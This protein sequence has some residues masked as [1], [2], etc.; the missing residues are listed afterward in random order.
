LA[1]Q[2]QPARRRISIERSFQA[3]VEE[4]WKLWTTKEGIESW[5]GPE[6]FMVKVRTLD[7]RRGG[8]LLYDMTAIAREQMDFLKKAGMPLTTPSRV[9]YVDVILLKRL[10]FTQVA[11]FI[12]GVKPYEVAH[13]V[14]FETGARGVRMILT[15]DA[16]H[17]DYWT[18][19][20]TMGWESEFDRLAALLQP[21]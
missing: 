13:A 19:M 15:M 3:P 17:D 9:T 2:T 16:M 12:P 7:V 8:E 6:G 14:D 10:A 1:Q 4:V 18:K 21:A 5:W 11:D 20:A